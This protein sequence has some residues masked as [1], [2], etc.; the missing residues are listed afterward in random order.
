MDVRRLRYFATVA[1][2]GSFT[3]AAAR[4][5]IAQSALS[6]QVRQLED[7]LGLELVSR[8]GCRV[9]ATNAGET[10]LRHVR[11]IERDFERLIEDMRMLKHTPNG[12]VVF[13]VPPAL[14]DVV[15]PPI[16]ERVQRE[17]PLIRI[18]IAEGISPVLA[19]WVQSNEVD[20]AIL[21]LSFE[22]DDE[23]T[24][25]LR[26]MTLTNEDM[27]IIEKAGPG[28]A[29]RA[30]SVQEIKTKP[31]VLTQKF[32][33]IVRSQLGLPDLPLNVVLEID[34]VQAIKAL[35]L[36][37]QAATILP[38]S[39]LIKELREGILV[40]SAITPRGVRRELTLAQP[41]FRQMTQATVV[42]A[43]LITEEVERMHGEGLFCADSFIRGGACVDR[44]VPLRPARLVKRASRQGAAPAAWIAARR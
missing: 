18:S 40:A 10:L 24:R 1:E 43:K 38:V 26:L 23:R 32:A 27:V 31:F 12:R 33:A 16:V 44:K 8:V 41:S 13:G 4:L 14:A 19:Q 39:M 9:K 36:N 20:I 6:R 28:G 17:Y 15:V 35:V 5:H 7:E 22:S 34:S 37:G 29:P 21:G 42:V 2:L 25:G 3:K 11:T 30:Y